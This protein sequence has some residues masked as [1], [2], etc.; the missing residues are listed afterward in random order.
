MH[1]PRP[2]QT[3]SV[4][5]CRAAYR[6]GA[7]AVLL[8]VP[9]GGGKTMIGS[10]VV[11]GAL[12]MGR[13]VLWLAHRRELVLQAAARMP[14][15]AGILMAGHLPVYSPVQ[16]GSIDTIAD[17]LAL[18]HADLVVYDEAHH[19]VANTSR[20]LLAKF[21]GA[22]VLGLTATP[23]RGDGGALGDV[24][25]RLVIGPS[26]RTLIDDGHLVESD[27]IGP[28]LS[29][30]TL[31]QDPVD[32]WIKHAGGRPGF[33]FCRTIKQSKECVE[34]LNAA[35]VPSAHVDGGTPKRERDAA[36][37][38]FRKCAIDVLSSVGVFTEGVDLP[39]SQVCMLARGCD[40]AATYLQMV[41][42][43]LR[44]S[45]GKT[46]ALV[47]DLVGMVHRHG[48][49][50]DDREWSL[51]GKPIKL[52]ESM[53]PIKQCPTC[54]AVWR[55]NKLRMC[56]RCQWL[57]PEPPAPTVEERELVNL[58]NLPR[59]PLATAEQKAEALARLRAEAAE[60]N[61]K[62]GWVGM[63]FQSQFGHWPAGL[64]RR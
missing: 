7:R 5:E 29:S 8:V 20:T 26:V 13:R 40:H 30:S 9:T 6:E 28:T 45:K 46:R 60:K 25:E 39:R 63:R 12:R 15:I 57:V 61:Y 36:I 27:V 44:P 50:D 47:I 22:H 2:Y 62:P 55:L 17:W 58:R 41:G 21:P 43:V 23:S 53:S 11:E 1:V 33:L 19:A 42:R 49:P 48:L 54:G 35:G 38:G 64:G 3:R 24:F 56:P 4:E 32:A 51:S 10:M 18:P 31:A 16:V 37:D 14:V 59:R 52:V 34:R